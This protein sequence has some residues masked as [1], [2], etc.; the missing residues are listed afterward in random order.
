MSLFPGQQ[1][2]QFTIEETLTFVL[3]RRARWSVDIDYPDLSEFGCH[4][5]PRQTIMIF[6]KL[7]PSLATMTVPLLLAP[8][9][10]CVVYPWTSSR[11]WKVTSCTSRMSVP[12][13]LSN[14]SNIA[15][16]VG[17]VIPFMFKVAILIE[18]FRYNCRGVWVRGGVGGGFYSLSLRVCAIVVLLLVRSSHIPTLF[19]NF[20]FYLG[21]GFVQNRLF[22][23]YYPESLVRVLGHCVLIVHPVCTFDVCQRFLTGAFF[24]L[25]VCMQG[26]RSLSGWPIV[27]CRYSRVYCYQF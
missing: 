2:R 19:S 26:S 12:W 27:K 21:L 22:V 11:T 25:R 8:M 14:A 7:I 4:G 16:L 3:H 24:S 10:Y 1:I 20:I 9:L 23:R 13:R 17:G 18:T 15:L 6:Y 5:A